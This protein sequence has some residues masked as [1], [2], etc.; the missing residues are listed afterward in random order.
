MRSWRVVGSGSTTAGRLVRITILESSQVRQKIIVEA[1][2]Q[3]ARASRRTQYYVRQFLVKASR[4]NEEKEE[5]NRQELLLS[6]ESVPCSTNSTS[7]AFHCLH[8]SSLHIIFS[9]TDKGDVGTCKMN[10]RLTTMGSPIV[11]LN[12]GNLYSREKPPVSTSPSSYPTQSTRKTA[13]GS[14]SKENHSP[15]PLLLSILRTFNVPL[16]PYAHYS[17]SIFAISAEPFDIS[18]STS[19]HCCFPYLHRAF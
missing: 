5:W 7:A 1:A 19:S 18:R 4:L 6:N 2:V 14:R 13:A 3:G 16:P 12:R 9:K 17:D 8:C 15:P 11:N 10:L